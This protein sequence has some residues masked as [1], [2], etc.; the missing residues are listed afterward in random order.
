MQN[1]VIKKLQAAGVR[2]VVSATG[3]VFMTLGQRTVLAHSARLIN[4]QDLTGLGLSP[5]DF[6]PT[7]G[8]PK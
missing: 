7:Q 8:N 1:T 2:V 3:T 6:L 5:A 4:A